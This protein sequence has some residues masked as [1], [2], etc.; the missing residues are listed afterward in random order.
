[1]PRHKLPN[2]AFQSELQTG[3]NYE[4]MVHSYLESRGVSC[5]PGPLR[6]ADLVLQDGRTLEVK[7]RRKAF[8][9]LADFSESRFTVDR[10]ECWDKKKPKPLAYI[11]VSQ[12]TGE[13]LWTPGNTSRYWFKTMKPNNRGGLAECYV[14]L[15]KRL[16]VMDELVELIK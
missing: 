7:S 12:I 14:C 4:R 5:A 3:I 11:I 6:G 8:T 13:M 9:G 15:K 2:R 1:M 10:K 16:R